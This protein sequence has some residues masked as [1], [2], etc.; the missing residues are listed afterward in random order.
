MRTLSI[1]EQGK[2]G[3]VGV[4]FPGMLS[5]SKQTSPKTLNSTQEKFAGPAVSSH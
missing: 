1:S 5:F 2:G 3:C 4:E